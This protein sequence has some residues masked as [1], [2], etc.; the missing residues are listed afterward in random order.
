MTT[1]FQQRGRM[2]LIQRLFGFTSV[3]ALGLA[4]MAN[5]AAAAEAAPAADAG[6]PQVETL[7]VTAQKRPEDVQQVPMSIT[8]LSGAQLERRDITNASDLSQFVPGLTIFSSNNNRNSTVAIR[9]IGSSGTNPGIEPS[10]GIFIDGV[11]MPAAGPIQSNLLDVSTLEVLR[12]PQGTLYGR[13]TPVGAINI[14][15]R[16]PTQDF[17]GEVEG[18]IGNYNER[19]V[20][21]YVGGGISQNV[22]GRLS[23]WTS[24]RE[25][26]ETNLESGARIDDA[27]QYGLRGRILWTPS[28]TVNVNFIGYYTE[29]HAN[30][31]AADQINPTGIGGI[32]T[33]AFLASMV[34]AGHP[35]RNFTSG[36]HQVDTLAIPDTTTQIAGGSMA[37]D[38]QLAHATFTSIS[39]FNHYDDNIEEQ[40]PSW[41]PLDVAHG[42]QRDKIDTLSQE[43]RIASSGKNRIDYVAGVYLYYSML[44]FGTD[45][46]VH[47]GANRVFPGGARLT[48]GDTG[49]LRFDQD[50]T[51][52]AGFGQATFNVTDR[53]RLTA[54]GRYSDD[55]KTGSIINV[56]NPGAS[57]IF[58]A[59]L[60]LPTDL[61]D[62]KRTDD[63]FTWALGA[64]YDLTDGIM[65]YVKAGTGF[66]DG[67]FNARAGGNFTVVSFDPENSKT[68]ELG[69]KSEF[70]DRRVVLNADVFHMELDGFQDSTLNPLTGS[71]FIVSNAGNRRVNGVE[72]DAQAQPLEQLSLTA[73]A[74]Y[75]DGVYTSYPAGQCPTYP[76]AF[77]AVKNV[78]PAGTCNFT[79]LRPANSPE[80]KWSLTGEWR[81]PIARA[82][83]LSWFLGGDISYTSSQFLDTTLDP[84]SFQPAVT[85]VGARFGVDSRTGWRVMA[86]AKNLTNESY[87][88]AAAAQPLAAFI[89]GGG[90]AAPQGFVGWYAPPRTYG[91]EASYKF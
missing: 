8:A 48:V 61:P 86:F 90:T 37:V 57:A 44:K 29:L 12:G 16:A 85:L 54:G 4:C 77:A 68:Y 33:P 42:D 9:G 67:G 45:T 47:A 40:A 24:T 89:S 38:W 21:G 28:S 31:C 52:V 59:Q 84:R 75:D 36:D 49:Q 26:Y 7:I 22:A 35:F 78:T 63:K 58:V 88:L 17:E 6:A 46:I 13:N 3:A 79:G 5:Q 74:S 62:L 87:Y 55:R 23:A 69:V 50:T 10:V 41:L 56:N 34:A 30:C 60:S 20:S 82:P 32:A 83:G 71:G 65:G 2:R 27:N 80:W 64:Q 91:L 18:E 15:T 1:L 51:G 66:K 70:L 19:R 76:G 25:G 53:F 72:V 73:A 39:A 14:T 11:Y 81:Q 43:F